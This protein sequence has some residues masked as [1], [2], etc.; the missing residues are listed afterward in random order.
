V[1]YLLDTGIWLWSTDSVHR[2]NDAGL[3]ILSS[4]REEVYFSAVTAWEVSIKMRLGKLQFPGPPSQT[5]PS[6]I[7]KQGLRPLTV[8]HLHAVGVY[9]LP[10][11]HG[12]PFD[13]LIIAQ[14]IAEKMV[15]LTADRAFQ[16]Y[17]VEVVWCGK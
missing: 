15:I 1:K 10:L 6:F 2:I 9:D 5:I 17:A 12:D 13:R 14:A 8:T 7:A 11:H 16:K 4:G 3:E